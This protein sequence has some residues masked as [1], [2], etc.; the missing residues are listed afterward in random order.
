MYPTNHTT[1]PHNHLSTLPREI[2]LQIMYNLTSCFDL[3]SLLKASPEFRG[4]YELNKET[5]L[6]RIVV[7]AVRLA[8]AKA[9]RYQ[10]H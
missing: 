7:N 5:V 3:P 6:K 1:A 9:G 2:L 10:S 8:D 4:V